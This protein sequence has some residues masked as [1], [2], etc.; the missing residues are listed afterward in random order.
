[1]TASGHRSDPQNLLFT[2]VVHCVDDAEAEQEAVCSG[3]FLLFSVSLLCKT[4]FFIHVSHT[5]A[6]TQW[7]MIKFKTLNS[8]FAV[9]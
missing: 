3:T 4:V 5:V 7:C 8:T 2:I 1:M 6:V 9:S